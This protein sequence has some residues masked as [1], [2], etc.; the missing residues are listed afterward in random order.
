[1]RGRY[2][3]GTGIGIITFLVLMICGIVVIRMVGLKEEKKKLEAH[4]MELS[5][6]I[7]ME[8]ERSKE[9]EELKNKMKSKD[10]IKKEARDKL[11]LVEKDDIILVP[12]EE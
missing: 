12:E 4:T 8:E 9:I 1:M 10:F 3:S 2:K 5:S 11:G 7:Q 6:Q